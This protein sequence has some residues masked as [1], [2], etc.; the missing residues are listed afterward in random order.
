MLNSPSNANATATAT[1]TATAGRSNTD[2][3]A[4]LQKFINNEEENLFFGSYESFAA[5]EAAVP[6][7]IHVGY[8]GA[9]D[10]QSMYS[11]QICAWDY[12][13][14]FWLADAFQNGMT[15]VCDLGGHVGIKYYAFRRVIDYPERLG[16]IVSDVPSV[17]AAG[18]ALAVERQ[19]SHQLS[20]RSDLKS[21]EEADILLLSGSLQYL[22]FKLS[23]ML[24]AVAHK[25]R[26]LILNITAAHSSQTIYTLNSI[27]RAICPYRIQPSDEILGE[28]RQNGYRRRDVWRNDGKPITIPFVEGGDKA[29]Y[30][31]CCF[32]RDSAQ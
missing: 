21:I 5:A 29:F 27:G 7:G 12:P 24:A 20:F 11:P 28:I 22:P 16:W 25:P 13:T 14:M 2:E 30:F 26:R 9:P 15:T 6:T 23:E 4:Y 19:C 18:E 1:A 32:D 10:A 17:A 31:G 3:S 8:D